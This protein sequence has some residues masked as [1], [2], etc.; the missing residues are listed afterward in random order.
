MKERKNQRTENPFRFTDSNKRYYT[1][2]YY[3]RRT[4]GGKCA[5][6]PLDGGFTCPNIDG[7]RGVGG[8][9]YCSGRGSGDFA[10]SPLLGI[11]E[12]YRLTRMEL[13]SKWSVERCIPYFQAHTNTDA[14]LER[15]KQ[16]YEEALRQEGVVGLN[17]ATRADCL[18]EGVPE[19]LA[20][21]AER[22]VLTVELGLQTVHDETARRINRGHTFEEFQEGFARLRQASGKIGICVHL[23]FGLPEEEREQMMETVDRVAE[24]HPDQVKIH[25]LHV[26]RNTALAEEYL[27]GKY[28]PLE[29][30]EYVTLVADAIQRLPED[31]VIARLTG[32]GMADDLLAPEWSRKKVSVINDIDKLLFAR[33]A[34]QG[35]N[36]KKT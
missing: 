19:Y 14:P 30:D 23:I 22:T 34:W 1:Y 36:Y 32:D 8:C 7:R 26:L 33:N 11:G 13:S 16:L 3:L 5:K 25:L 21:L 35:K 17:I 10:Q 28:R 20:E 31:I 24:L 29:K 9:T 12:Q 18:G 2:D 15:L 4:F 6:I 27:A